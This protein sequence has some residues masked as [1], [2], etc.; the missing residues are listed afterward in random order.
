MPALSPEGAVTA[1]VQAV[2]RRLLSRTDQERIVD[3]MAAAQPSNATNATRSLRQQLSHLAF[4]WR[5]W[6]VG[7]DFSLECQGD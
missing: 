3:L 7:G 1:I 2:P 4:S 6:I 5:R